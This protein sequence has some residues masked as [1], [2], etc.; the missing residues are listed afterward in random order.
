MQNILV[1]ANE[2]SS[3]S[4][5]SSLRRRQLEDA[6][7][8]DPT[9]HRH[10]HD[11]TPPS[12]VISPPDSASPDEVSLLNVLSGANNFKVDGLGITQVAGNM[13]SRNTEFNFILFSFGTCSP[14]V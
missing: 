14:H 4:A 6:H 9:E 2:E 12:P 3:Y 13:D 10:T 8:E 7:N 11:N 1:L 5:H